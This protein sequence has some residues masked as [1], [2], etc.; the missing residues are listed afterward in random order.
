MPGLGH[1]SHEEQPA[2]TVNLILDFARE[3]GVLP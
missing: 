2:A 1:L 3:T